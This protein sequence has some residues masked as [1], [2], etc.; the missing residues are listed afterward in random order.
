MSRDL[1]YDKRMRMWARILFFVI[2]L[3][4]PV[5]MISYRYDFFRRIDAYSI[6]FVGAVVLIILM[7]RFRNELIAWVNDWE[8]SAFKHIILG[9]NRVI[10]PILIYA[11]IKLGQRGVTD[12]IFV[13]E[14][15]T[16]TTVI[17]YLLVLPIEKHYDFHVKRELRKKEMREVR[18]E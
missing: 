6:T 10:V 9:L 1:K 18:D 3:L 7:Y 11:I 16:L 4:T 5:V 8:Y 13:I 15:I 12:L 17:G 14:W 2:T